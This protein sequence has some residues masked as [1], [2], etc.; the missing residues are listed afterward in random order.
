MRAVITISLL[1]GVLAG[2]VATSPRNL[3]Q[4]GLADT[5][6]GWQ[7]A[8]ENQLAFSLATASGIARIE[9]RPLPGE[10]EVLTLDMPGMEKVE[11][12]QWLGSDGGHA[13]L[14]SGVPEATGVT[15]ERKPRG[16]R[17]VI[18]GEALELIRGGGVL[19]VIDYYRG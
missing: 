3:V 8:P 11:G 1:V 2:C 15:L 6:L 7:P 18:A 17:L 10:L 5:H 19:T 16:F 12:V 9:L 13:M 14:F 4:S